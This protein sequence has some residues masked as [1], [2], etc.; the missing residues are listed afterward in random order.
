MSSSAAPTDTS[1]QYEVADATDDPTRMV[2][3]TVTISVQDVP[4]PVSNF[5]VSEF[6]D[7]TLK[8]AWA[9][10]AFNNSPITEYRV[11]M[12]DATT[13]ATLSTTSCTVTVGC[14][15]TT[16]GNGPTHAVRL[17][18]VAVNAIG[19]SSATSLSAPSGPTSFRRRPPTCR[20][21]RSTTASGS[22]GPSR[23]PAAR[24]ARSIST[25]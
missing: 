20:H 14:A 1:L 17:S 5:R 13:A 16:P 22:P 15:I 19:V 18:V 9:P 2:W 11:T 10:G 24:P 25:C 3:G 12:S 4:D 23:R 7:R 6:G 21:P 8:L